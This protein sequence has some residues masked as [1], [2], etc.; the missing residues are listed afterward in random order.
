[1][2][3]H[4]VQSTLVVNDV[5]VHRLY[6]EETEVV[7]YNLSRGRT[8]IQMRAPAE[9]MFPL[10]REAVL[11]SAAAAAGRTTPGKNTPDQA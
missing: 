1:M 8:E 3:P 9:S 6:A 7:T 10:R 2:N 4:S 11:A 5:L